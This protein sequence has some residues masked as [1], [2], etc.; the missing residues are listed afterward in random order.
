MDRAAAMSDPLAAPEI[1]SRLTFDSVMGGRRTGFVA[2]TFGT[3]ARM[4]D[5]L[6]ALEDQGWTWSEW[7]DWTKAT[8][9]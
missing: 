5:V 2:A 6:A 7:I 8:R 4:M 1:G 9:P 3:Q